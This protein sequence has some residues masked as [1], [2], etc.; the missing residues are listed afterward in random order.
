MCYLFG[1]SFDTYGSAF[2]NPG[3]KRY[4][5][6]TGSLAYV[7][8]GISVSQCDWC[9]KLGP[10]IEQIE[11]DKMEAVRLCTLWLSDDE[12]DDSEVV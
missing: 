2:F 10:S 3:S 5:G 1:H 9:N 4:T 12:D 6:H 8:E 7:S 11:S